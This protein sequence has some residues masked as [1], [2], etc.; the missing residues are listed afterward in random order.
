MSCRAQCGP[1]CLLCGILYLRAIFWA[2]KRLLQS[3]EGA[4]DMSQ[5]RTFKS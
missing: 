1:L 3:L 5:A 4:Q 2:E